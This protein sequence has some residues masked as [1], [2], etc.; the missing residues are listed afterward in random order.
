MVCLYLFVCTE[1][2]IKIIIIY[3][4]LIIKTVC[5]N[6]SLFGIFKVKICV[7]IN[8]IFLEEQ[9]MIVR[10]KQVKCLTFYYE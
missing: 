7:E 4:Q 8:L 5:S 6:L 3:F 9:S 10:W 2:P 1:N